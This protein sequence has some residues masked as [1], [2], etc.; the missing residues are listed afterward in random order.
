LPEGT[1]RLSLRSKGR[2]NVSAIAARLGGGGHENASGVT[3]D[4]PIARAL[5]VILAELRP[6]V[7]GPAF[8]PP[9]V[10]QPQDAFAWENRELGTGLEVSDE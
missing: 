2:V 1:I 10:A 7:E 9:A 8:P 5:E 3:M 6:S 4:G